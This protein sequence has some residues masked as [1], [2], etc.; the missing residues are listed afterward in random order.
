MH[1]IGANALAVALAEL[2]QLRT[3]AGLCDLA[4]AIVGDV[5]AD[6][7]TERHADPAA[8]RT[9]AGGDA[10]DRGRPVLVID[11]VQRRDTAQQRGVGL[12]FLLAVGAEAARHP[13]GMGEPG[14]HFSYSVF[15][16]PSCIAA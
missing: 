13:A 1:A 6:D 4:A 15:H 5:A 9:Q 8:G 7:K 10:I 12:A 16:V 3:L 11:G 2:Q 14:N